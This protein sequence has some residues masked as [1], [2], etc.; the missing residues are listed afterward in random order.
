MSTTGIASRLVDPL[1]LTDEDSADPASDLHGLCDALFQYLDFEMLYS[2][3]LDGV[4]DSDH[5]RLLGMESLRPSD[6][7]ITY[8][9][10]GHLTT[11]PR[12]S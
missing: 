3:E 5:G 1:V 11:R 8:N 6:W 9:N 7:F 4:E 12:R 2:P 10:V